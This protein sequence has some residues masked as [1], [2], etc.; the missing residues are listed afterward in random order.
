MGKRVPIS[1]RTV[2]RVQ[3]YLTAKDYL[4]LEKYCAKKKR[5]IGDVVRDIIKEA[6]NP[7]RTSDK[8]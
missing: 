3:S 6:L 2:H 4:D 8:I 5:A 7:T 1:D